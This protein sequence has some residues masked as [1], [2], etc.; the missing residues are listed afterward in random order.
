MDNQN[1]QLEHLAEMR[2]LME[3][4]SR[5]ISL[6][7]MS[8][9]FAGLAGLLGAGLMYWYYGLEYYYPSEAVYNL[10]GTVKTE[11]LQFLF[12]DAAAVLCFALGFGFFFNRRKAKRTGSKVWDKTAKRVM[13]NMLIPLIA[14]AAF[15]LI[16]LKHG[17]I[18]YIAS[19]TLM[20]YGMALVNSSKY[21]LHDIRYLG[22]CEIILGLLSAY[23]IGY[24]LIFWAIGFGLLHI[25]YG[26]VMYIKYEKE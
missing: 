17:Q 24:G 1:E 6:S 25:I 10:N 21:T 19:I 11:F 16:M 9:V 7:G 26:I 14:G 18:E 22:I 13:I 15:G 4:S 2:S 5:F 20:F 8:G 12:A 3:K 23:F